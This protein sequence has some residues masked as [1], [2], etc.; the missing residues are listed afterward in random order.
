MSKPLSSKTDT[1]DNKVLWPF[2]EDLHFIDPALKD[3]TWMSQ[4]LVFSK[5]N[6]QPLI[7]KERAKI[8][9]DLDEGRI[10]ERKYKEIFDP[11]EDGEGGTAEYISADWKSNPI[12]IHLINIVESGLKKIPLNIYCR[13]VD[14]YA[15]SK[16]QKDNEKIIMRN[17]IRSLINDINSQLGYPK[18]RATDDPAVYIRQMQRSMAN[19]QAQGNSTTPGVLDMIRASIADDE[20]IALWNEYIYK[21]DVE[22]A[23]ELGIQEYIKENK[24]KKIK[25]NKV[26]ADIRNHNKACIM[27]YTDATNGQPRI[28][29]M[30][31]DTVYISK[32]SEQDGGDVTSWYRESFISFSNFIRKFGSNRTPDQLR[33]IFDLSKK[34]GSHNIDWDR[35]TKRQKDNAMIRVGYYEVETQDCDVYSDG[36]RNGNSSYRKVPYDW[37][38]SKNT[39]KKYQATREEKHY[40]VWY[41]CWY[42]PL[43]G[44]DNQST[45]DNYEEQA[46]YIYDFGKVQDQQRFGDAMRYAKSSLIMWS[47]NRMTFGDV[48]MRFMGKI[49]HLWFSFQNDLGN[50]IP[51]G[52]LFAEEA[53]NLM[54]QTTD[55]A[56]KA[57][58]DSKRAFIKKLRQTGSGIAKMLNKEG[59]VVND[60]KPFIEVKSGH[61]ASALEKLT[62]MQELYNTMTQAL[63]ISDVRE[64]NDPKPRT[65]LGGINLALEASNNATYNMEEA[66]SDLHM[67]L[68]MRLLRYIIEICNE[69]DSPRFKQFSAIVGK[70]NSLAMESI[71]DI[72][73]HELGLYMD[74][75]NT[76][77]MKA[78][79][80]QLVEKMVEAK[81]IGVEAL[82]LIIKEENYKYAAVLMILKY[83]E[84]QR[85]QEA[86]AEL[87]FKREMAL[88][89]KDIEAKRQE[90]MSRGEADAKVEQI[91]QQ[92]IRG[93]QQWLAVW[94]SNAQQML[95]DA[96]KSA[97]IEEK[98]TT[99][100]KEAEVA[101]AGQENILK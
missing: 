74:D 39:V 46:K 24:Y 60:G 99:L 2:Y 62:L 36:V 87:Q 70:G 71:R 85:K 78:E 73:A 63:G 80:N 14:E 26:I 17:E 3:E 55:D 77:R 49:N 16:K 13:A 29:Y 18:L 30:E 50:H 44:Y 31:P 54:M 1:P 82:H 33:E 48:M 21:G 67:E 41:K 15:K 56:N 68:Q 19:G 32:S 81:M 66:M 75:V 76:D 96:R 89:D 65:S 23:C 28:D 91:K 53:I 100:D 64:G 92:L 5:R 101:A 61:L 69:G 72:P 25:Q 11:V 43:V 84:F 47:S 58:K 34:N 4:A 35:C 52:I 37:Q 27:Y 40:N 8:F 38:P 93:T 90:Y 7:T 83:K 6:N 98:V 95:N 12:Y 94:K 45:G 97:K 10:D 59:K 22:I 20:G 9:L 51:H 79:L 57:G 88:K 86:M 42:I